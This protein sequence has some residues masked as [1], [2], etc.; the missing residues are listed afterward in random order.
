MCC[1]SQ[2]EMFFPAWLHLCTMLHRFY[3]VLFVRDN[4]WQLWFWGIVLMEAPVSA[5]LGNGQ[6]LG[7]SVLFR[8]LGLVTKVLAAYFLA[9]YLIPKLLFR[10]KYLLFVVITPIA[11]VILSVLARFLNIYIGEALLYP[12]VP[13]E[14]LLEIITRLKETIDMYLGRFITVAFWFAFI[15]IGVDQLRSEKQVEQLSKEKA[16]AELSLL[17]AQIHPHFLFNT[18]NNLYALTVEK[19]DE[20]PGVVA[21]LAAM[22][23]YLLYHCNVPRVPIRRE[24]ELIENYIQLEALRYGARLDLTFTHRIDDEQASVAPLMLISPVENAFKHGSSGNIEAPAIDIELIVEAGVLTFNVWNNKSATPVKD[25]ANYTEGIG[26]ANVQSQLQMIYPDRHTL[27]ITS[28]EQ[29]YTV[30]LRIEL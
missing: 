15:K 28:D 9:Y 26:L 19:S 18:L 30:D 14:N 29:E 13:N 20:A 10:R 2:A 7:E 11:A 27:A 21:R 17:K 1:S 12:D 16:R 23:D 22:L 4:R 8:V 6:G 5:A 25:E 24:I 3:E